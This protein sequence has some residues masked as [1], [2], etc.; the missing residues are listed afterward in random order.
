MKAATENHRK[1]TRYLSIVGGL[2]WP[3]VCGVLF[4]WVFFCFQ[5]HKQHLV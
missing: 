1:A 5:R 2:V 4:V 3:F